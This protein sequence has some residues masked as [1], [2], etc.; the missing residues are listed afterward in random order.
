MIDSSIDTSRAAWIAPSAEL[1]GDV[2]IHDGVSIWPQSVLRVEATHIEI[3]AYT[4][5]QDFV[6]VHFGS[7]GESVIGAYCSITHH[8][9]IHGANI[10]D[11]CLIGINA[12]IMDGAVIGENSIVAGNSI[13]REG[14]VI[15]PNSIV[16]GVPGK[17][18]AE[19][20]N[21]IDNKMNA[22]A[23]HENALGYARG[24]YRRWSDPDY[25]GLILRRRAEIEAEFAAAGGS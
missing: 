13:V 8:A 11:C 1:Y 19:R 24:Y 2:R 15:P 9:T 21:Y 5:L 16:A 23:Y 4:N 22:V 14:T 20:N 17:V 6:M 18:I 12:T 10:G 7:N 25:E 3:G